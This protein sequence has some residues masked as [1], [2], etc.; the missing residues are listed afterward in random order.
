VK[1]QAYYR[2]TGDVWSDLVNAPVVQF[3]GVVIPQVLAASERA[4]MVINKRIT[5]DEEKELQR[6]QIQAETMKITRGK[7]KA[8]ERARVARENELMKSTKRA[9]H[10]RVICG[11]QQAQQRQKQGR[12]VNDHLTM[13]ERG[14]Q[15]AQTAQPRPLTAQPRARH[16]QRPQICSNAQ[17]TDNAPRGAMQIEE[18]GLPGATEEAGE[19]KLAKGGVEADLGADAL[20]REHDRAQREGAIVIQSAIRR[21]V[22]STKLERKR[23]GVAQPT[24]LDRVQTGEE[25]WTGEL[26]ATVSVSTASTVQGV[27]DGEP[28]NAQ[29]VSMIRRRGHWEVEHRPQL[30]RPLA[31]H[32]M[33]VDYKKTMHRHKKSVGMEFAGLITVDEAPVIRKR[34]QILK[35]KYREDEEKEERLIGQ[36]RQRV[37]RLQREEEE[38]KRR[39]AQEEKAEEERMHKLRA[40]RERKEERKKDRKAGKKVDKPA[41]GK[42]KG[43]SDLLETKD[44]AKLE[45]KGQEEQ[46]QGQG[47]PEHRH[48]GT[49]YSYT[50]E[51]G[52]QPPSQQVLLQTPASPQQSNP[53]IP[54]F[55]EEAQQIAAA[56]YKYDAERNAATMDQES[57]ARLACKEIETFDE[58][59]RLRLQREAKE[60]E[61]EKQVVQVE[62]LLGADSSGSENSDDG[63]YGKLL[64]QGWHENQ[65]RPSERAVWA[66][67]FRSRYQCN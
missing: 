3:K 12:Q 32:K 11:E 49:D 53:P 34:I 40:A 24:S 52:Q 65:H 17:D 56:E 50:V 67:Q 9:G 28:R 18:K 30:Y 37:L 21:R 14:K 39:F 13:H 36:E 62:Q 64:H 51:A 19:E 41:G 29:G 10:I 1:D 5:D 35:K 63:A 45:K 8:R 48:A 42:K 31:N 57:M 7:F 44:V 22:A 4:E 23:S 6:N 43:M 58:G 33:K 20:T 61:K 55:L 38:R 15:R 27:S 54:V 59:L 2:N 46:E 26:G 66:S 47:Q 25:L 60:A 16:G